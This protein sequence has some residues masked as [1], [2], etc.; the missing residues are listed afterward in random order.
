[1]KFIK[2]KKTFASPADDRFVPQQDIT[3]CISNMCD[4][5]ATSLEAWSSHYIPFTPFKA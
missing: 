3:Q 2:K 4:N 1:M 5:T